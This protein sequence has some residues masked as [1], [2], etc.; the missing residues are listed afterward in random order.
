M[1]SIQ[2]KDQFSRLGYFE[3][4]VGCCGGQV[5]FAER[6][7]CVMDNLIVFTFYAVKDQQILKLAEPQRKFGISNNGEVQ[8][9]GFI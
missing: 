4:P 7:H 1:V 9:Y 2:S 3:F 8:M 5:G 6:A